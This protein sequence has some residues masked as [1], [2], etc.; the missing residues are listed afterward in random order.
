MDRV[1][2][3]VLRYLEDLQLLMLTLSSAWP[4]CS[5]TYCCV[6][7][8]NGVNEALRKGCQLGFFWEIWRSW[9]RWCR[10][11]WSSGWLFHGWYLGSTHLKFLPKDV[12]LSMI[13]IEFDD[14]DQVVYC[15][16]GWLKVARGSLIRLRKWF[17][18][19]RLVRVLHVISA[20][21]G[22]QVYG[23]Y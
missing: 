13:T 12:I 8:A 1:L 15:S 22:F 9:G 19:M 11:C 17:S 3:V 2:V 6:R 10:A 18:V 21:I 5:L 23:H 16:G 7:A 14:D 20:I 4:S